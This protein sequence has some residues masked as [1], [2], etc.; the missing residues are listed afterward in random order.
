MI[1]IPS[2]NTARDVIA[3]VPTMVPGSVLRAERVVVAPG[4]KPLNVARFLGSAGVPCRLVAVADA[5][6]V[7]EL[8]TLLGASVQRQLVLT[9]SACRV[10]LHIVDGQGDLTVVNAPP[11]VLAKGEVEAGLMATA[12]VLEGGDVLLLAGSQPPGVAERLA[13]IAAERGARLAVDCSG[14]DLVTG[15]SAGPWLAKVN[16]DELVVAIGGDP[17]TA[18]RAARSLAPQPAI[19]AVTRGERGARAWPADGKPLEAR[20]PQTTVVNPLAAGD[21]LFAGLLTALEAGR[22][23]REALRRGMAWASAVAA[24]L[25]TEL[26]L[27]LAG[28]L[29]AKVVVRSFIAGHDETKTDGGRDVGA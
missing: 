9:Q 22:D 13:R 2:L 25:E 5:T 11:A 10:D 19:L 20:P 7:A 1:V 23:L 14:F 16:A 24:R 4:G 29:E 8:T 12:D 3:L 6:T 21:A 26:D 28:R 17:E 27:E 18:W 15:L